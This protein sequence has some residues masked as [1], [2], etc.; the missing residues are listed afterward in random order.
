M[1]KVWSAFY[2]EVIPSGLGDAPLSV[3]D[4]AVRNATIEFCD[5]SFVLRAE[6]TPIDVLAADTGEY[7]WTPPANRKVVRAERVF[8][9]K[10]ELE[11][12]TPDEISDMYAY[13]PDAEGTPLYFMQQRVEK[14]IIVPA[15]NIDMVAAIRATVSIK[16]TRAA[17]DIDDEIWE[18]YLETIACGA[19]ARLYFMKNMPYYDPQKAQAEYSIFE[20]AISM[21]ALKAFHGHVRSRNNQT[22]GWRRFL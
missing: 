4:N 13:W 19:R 12:K 10:K 2:Q 14:I 3:V 9:N 5:R 18:K 21:A 15:P 6:I 17:A 20:A 1:A 16:P 7:S 22:R 8:F 11:P